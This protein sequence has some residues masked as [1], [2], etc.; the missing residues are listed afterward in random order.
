MAKNRTFRCLPSSRT[1]SSIAR[2]LVTACRKRA[3]TS[4][5]GYRH[6]P[7]SLAIAADAGVRIASG[8]DLLGPIR[9]YQ[10]EKV[11]IKARAVGAMGAMIAPTRTHAELFGFEQEIGTIEVGKQADF[12]VADGDVL[13]DLDYSGAT[14]S[15][16]SWS[17]V[18]GWSITGLADRCDALMRCLTRRARVHPAGELPIAAGGAIQGD[19]KVRYVAE[20]SFASSIGCS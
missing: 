9:G 16:Y 14:A 11:A 1:K 12:V 2:A 8:S 7:Q 10:G 13:E 15:S 18:A 3:S 5:L 20:N 6:R 17:S 4:W 19:S